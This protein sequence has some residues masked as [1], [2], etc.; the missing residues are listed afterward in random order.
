MKKLLFFLLS[1]CIL[2]L[3]SAYI[4][5]PSKLEISK[6]EY[7]N[8][9]VNGAFRVLSNEKTWHKWW[10]EDTSVNKRNDT[11]SYLFFYK[12]YS[13]HLSEKLYNA[14][15][16]SITHAND[17]IESKIIIIKLNIDS[18]V[19]RW[20]CVLKTSFNPVSRIL[21]YNEAENI[22]N[23]MSEILSGLR[24]FLDNK[25]NIYGINLHVIMSKDST[26]VL[27]KNFSSRYPTTDEIYMLIGN[28]K[29]YIAS[30]KAKENNFPML[31]V[32]KLEDSTFETMVAIPVNK[33]LAGNG[34]ISFSRF[35]PW[36][37]LTAEVKGGD[38]TVQE[39]LHQM[40]V[41]ISDYQKTAMAIPFESL[42]T[43]R[44]KEPDTTKWITNIY[45][46]VP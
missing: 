23:N 6:V 34:Q 46:P 9:N 19:V 20:D 5:I 39:A 2:G 29:K 38:K 24:I 31:H 18:V 16:L 25:E 26:M 42:V 45:T 13:Y 21:K 4:F 36:K 1:L 43:D 30:Q 28:L 35:V 44:S 3:A 12:G 41:F 27:T 40:K 10:P 14:M 15:K 22:K 8:C 11:S 7:I 32:K 33:E 37:V 17:T